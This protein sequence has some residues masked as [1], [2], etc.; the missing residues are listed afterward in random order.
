ML[1]HRL[2]APKTSAGN[3]DRFL[4]RG[5]GKGLVDSR[6]WERIT[7]GLRAT[8]REQERNKGSEESSHGNT[9]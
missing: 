6:C 2:D 4:F 5:H 1:K 9:S 8:P 7:G 3:Y